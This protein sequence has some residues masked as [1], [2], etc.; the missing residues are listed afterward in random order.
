[1]YVEMYEPIFLIIVFALFGLFVITQ[2]I[3]VGNKFKELNLLGKLTYLLSFVPIIILIIYD[4][5]YGYWTDQVNDIANGPILQYSLGMNKEM[6]FV[7]MSSVMLNF[8]KTET[9]K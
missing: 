6:I 9:D 5:G 1:M 2:W 4:T 3:I 7:L 8:A